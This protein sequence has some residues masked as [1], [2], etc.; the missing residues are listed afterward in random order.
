MAQ[1]YHFSLP[2]L[3]LACVSADAGLAHAA[4][5]QTAPIEHIVIGNS[6]EPLY[7]P[8]KFHVGDSPIDP[9]NHSPLWSEPGFDDSTWETV[10]LT[11][12][13]RGP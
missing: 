12:T 6:A 10:D 11:P 3:L 7:G 4:P 13:R 8:W 9:V 2:L 5:A 1:S